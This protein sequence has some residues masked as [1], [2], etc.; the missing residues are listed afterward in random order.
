[1]QDPANKASEALDRAARGAIELRHARAAVARLRRRP[2][3]IV[4][5]CIAV[6]ERYPEARRGV[7]IADARLLE[8]ADAIGVA[9][10]VWTVNDPADAMRLRD[11]GVGAVITDGRDVILEALGG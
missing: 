8:L 6:P 10:H 4:G 3:T 1:M 9:V 11:L 2:P 5:R 7:A